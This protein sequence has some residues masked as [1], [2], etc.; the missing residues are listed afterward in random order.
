M[1]DAG[2]GMRDE[3]CGMRWHQ[4]RT[5]STAGHGAG[6]LGSADSSGLEEV[7]IAPGREEGQG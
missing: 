4:T 2:C 1:K 6:G 5:A 7:R 3:G